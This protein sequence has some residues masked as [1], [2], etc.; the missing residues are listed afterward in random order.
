MH[1]Q[2]KQEILEPGDK[3]YKDNDHFSNQHDSYTPKGLTRFLNCGCFPLSFGCAG[4]IILI[5]AIFHFL[6][7]L[8]S[9]LF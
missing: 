8:C 4:L 9:L 1:Q 6:S 5:I 2:D 7:Y 3:N